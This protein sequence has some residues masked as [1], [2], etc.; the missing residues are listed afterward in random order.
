MPH[1]SY[2]PSHSHNSCNLQQK[3][4]VEINIQFLEK[5]N[6]EYEEE[7]KK[8]KL[9]KNKGVPLLPYKLVKKTLQ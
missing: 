5:L 9:K 6:Q 3:T 4:F 7:L 2:V 1:N 8:N